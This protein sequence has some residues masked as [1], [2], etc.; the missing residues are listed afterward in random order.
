MM[1]GWR[2]VALGLGVAWLMGGQ[3]ARA[4]QQA[5]PTAAEWQKQFEALRSQV[6]AMQK[7]LDEIKALL[8]PL[9]AQRGG[10]LSGDLSIELGDRPVKGDPGA[11]LTFLEL[12]DYQ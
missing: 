10:A 5:S 3:P 12:T 9:R 11:K 4:Q 2:G 7:D 6:Q 1:V 8:A